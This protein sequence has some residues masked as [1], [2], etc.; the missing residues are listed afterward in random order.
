VL[1]DGAISLLLFGVLLTALLLRG[2][3]LL[4]GIDDGFW[5]NYLLSPILHNYKN[6][7]LKKKSESL[8]SNK[9]PAEYFTGNAWIEMLVKN[10][11]VP[12]DAARVTFEP[13]ARNNW[14]THPAGQILIVTAGKG[15]IQKKGE[16]VQLLLPGDVVSIKAGEV[17]WHGATPDS[18]FTHI[19]IQP[20]PDNKE[21][22]SWLE[23][24]TDEEYS[25]YKK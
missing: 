17:H 24:V 8:Q 19:A 7:M 6:F 16:A 14:H 2:V 20:V 18:L 9:A 11:G 12:C 3:E 22:M 10:E 5:L 21:E 23:R 1:N 13:G 25:S 15:C 4:K